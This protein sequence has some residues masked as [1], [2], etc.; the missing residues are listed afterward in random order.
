M[1]KLKGPEDHD[2][3]YNTTAKIL[4]LANKLR[5]NP[6]PAE[7]ILWKALKGKKLKGL[8]FRRQH[9]IGSFFVDF[10]CHQAKLVVE[11][12]G[13]I[14]RVK[15]V[16]DHDIGRENEIK[17]LGIRVLRFTNEQVIG[18]LEFVLKEIENALE[19]P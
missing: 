19:I 6:T 12:D 10:Y 8:K 13:S 9:P 7:E 2:F 11:V 5:L 16:A 4:N 3:Y 17:E 18:N 14:H 1:V 15:S